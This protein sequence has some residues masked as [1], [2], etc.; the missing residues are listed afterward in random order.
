MFYTVFTVLFHKDKGAIVSVTNSMSQFCM[1][2]PTNSTVKL[3]NGNTVHDQWFGLFYVAL[4]NVTLHIQW[5]PTPPNQVASNFILVFKILHMKLLNI[6]TLLTLKVFLG[7]KPI[8][9]KTISNI[10][11][12][13]LSKS[14]LKETGILLSQLSV[15]YL[16]KIFQI[17]HQRFG[18][19][20][21]SRLKQMTRKGRTEG[22]PTNPNDSE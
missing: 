2:V 8:R 5:D 14:T 20:S 15:R 9:P 3:A 19:V 13:K 12:L 6:V 11:K 1:F 4:L 17:I 18:H 10:F 16:K 22:L 7:Y 21:I